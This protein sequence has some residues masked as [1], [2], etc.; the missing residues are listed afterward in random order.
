MGI[1]GN[2]GQCN[3]AA[4]NTFQDSL[5]RYRASCG[6]PAVSLNLP[7]IENVG[8]VA[9]RPELLEAMSATGIGSMSVEELLAVLDY[10][11][12][13]LRGPLT[14]DK[15]QV[16]I[17]PGLPHELMSQ[18][19]AQPAWMRDPLFSQLQQLEANVPSSYEAAAKREES[20][21]SRIAAAIS[22][23]EAEDIVLEAL[24]D[25]L[26][27]VLNVERPNL[28][29]DKPLHAY[30]V[31]SL[32]AVDVRSWMIKDLGS[33]MTVFEINS[34]ASIQHLAKTVTSKNRFLPTFAEVK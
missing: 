32:V 13:L 11:C 31:D 30:G 26:S 9:E 23:P 2:K 21:A 33:K 15:A 25:K 12:G 5:A 34:Q 14:L 17:R 16:I 1:I 29:I 18:S 19:I 22:L 7:S 3:Y 24:L 6:L 10:H 8:F 28:D 27:R 20:I 4:G